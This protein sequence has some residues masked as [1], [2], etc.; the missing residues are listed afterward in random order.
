M[1]LAAH[2]RGVKGVVIDG[3][4]RDLA[5]LN[6]VN[7]PVRALVRLG[8]SLIV[9]Q[10]F[11]RGHSTLGQSPFTRPSTINKP[12]IIVPLPSPLPSPYSTPFPPTTVN[13]Y[14]LILADKDG[15]VVVAPSQLDQVLETAEEGRAVDEL[16]R[17][18][19]LEGKGLKETFEKRRGK[20]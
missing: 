20:K 9:T 5:E 18:D 15:I 16:C 7:L 10:V 2:M 14:D 8:A 17:L 6:G 13:A 4:C 11:A 19:L 12:L 1:G 3:R